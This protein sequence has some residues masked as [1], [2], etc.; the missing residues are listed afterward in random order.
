M[1]GMILLDDTQYLL[2]PRRLSQCFVQVHMLVPLQDEWNE[3]SG[4]V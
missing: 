3:V 2:T 1:G 4:C